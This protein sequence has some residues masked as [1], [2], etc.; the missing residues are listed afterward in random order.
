MWGSP[1]WPPS[2][3]PAVLRIDIEN[4]RHLGRKLRK[5]RR[6]EREKS[7]RQKG[8]ANRNRTRHKVAIAHNEV[9]RARRDYHHKQALALVR[10]NQ[11]IH[12]EDLHI[13]GMVR[14]RRLAR[15][16]SD[17][18]S[19]PL[20]VFSSRR[21]TATANRALGVAVAGVEQNLLDV[22]TPARRTPVTNP[23]SACPMCQVVHDRDH[24]PPR[25]FSPPGGQRD[26]TTVE[27]CK[28]ATRCGRGCRSRKP[29]QRRSR[30]GESSAV[31]SGEH[32][33]SDRLL[34][35]SSTFWKG[36]PD[37]DPGEEGRHRRRCIGLRAGDRRALASGAPTSRCWTGPLG[38]REV[39]ESVGGKFHEVDVTDFAG[40]EQVLADAVAGAGRAAHR[41]HHCR[42]RHRR[43]HHQQ[44]G[45]HRLD[46]FRQTVE[47]NL[48]G[49]FKIS[50]LGGGCT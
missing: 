5:L 25:S 2:P 7:R 44:D 6:L 11:V 30:H 23:Q 31:P 24:K 20:C 27:P 38:R 33:K 42:W 34:Y 35:S 1:G 40:T 19:G 9:A 13:A 10:E 37:G 47:L 45:P 8:S 41:R 32:V 36:K 18:G 39:A 28:T 21:P 4:P 22:R 29:P 3:P 14:N 15:T 16:I 17:A 46:S 48:I 50:R 43:A 12:V 26:K 49:T